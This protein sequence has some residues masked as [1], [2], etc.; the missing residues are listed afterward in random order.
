[1]FVVAQKGA[2]D[3]ILKTA[4]EI[5]LDNDIINN[6]N[7]SDASAVGYAKATETAVNLNSN[8]SSSNYDDTLKKDIFVDPLELSSAPLD[9]RRNSLTDSI[10]YPKL[11][12]SAPMAIQINYFF[13]QVIELIKEKSTSVNLENTKL[14]LKS[15]TALLVEAHSIVTSPSI[16]VDELQVTQ[17][18]IIIEGFIM[19]LEQYG[20]DKSLQQKVS[21]EWTNCCLESDFNSTRCNFQAKYHKELEGS[22]L[23]FALIDGV[24]SQELLNSLAI[25]FKENRPWAVGLGHQFKTKN[26][27]MVGATMVA[28]S[29]AADAS[30]S[31][32][33]SISADG[34]FILSKLDQ[35]TED[36]VRYAV[37]INGR[38][39]NI[40]S[41]Y[42]IVE[43]ISLLMG[44]KEIMCNDICTEQLSVIKS[45]TPP[46]YQTKL[47]FVEGSFPDEIKL[48]NNTLQ[49]I[50]IFRVLHFLDPQML[51]LA[52]RKIHDLLEPNGLLI[53]SAETPYL[54][55]WK[56]FIPEYESKVNNN[57]PWPGYIADT[58]S[59]E[60]AG[61]SKKLPP[62]MHFLDVNVITRLLTE[63]GFTVEKCTTF[64][65]ASTF[66][67]GLLLDGRESVGAIARK[68]I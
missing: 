11:L 65:R 63:N 58:S 44:A 53:L 33:S 10:P 30:G 13:G 6:M 19:Y 48:P 38:G 3:I 62:K 8:S 59:Y 42:G 29:L 47:H 16:I 5:M 2:K 18:G 22:L 39:L 51:I 68:A 67:P 28:S 24:F 25:D 55:N 15:L 64:D 37:S 7:P 45:L 61:Y 4:S 21:T 66:P 17:I 14:H 60:T 23:F 27:N 40:G 20:L 52:I 46:N 56:K 12:M 54:G 31:F 35:Y 41:G 43:R 34:G 36:F 49:L 26:M 32:I 9:S 50:G 57:E 1:M